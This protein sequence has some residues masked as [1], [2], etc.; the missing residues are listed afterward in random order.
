[1]PFAQL[2]EIRIDLTKP[3]KF[4]QILKCFRRGKEIWRPAGGNP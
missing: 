4:G 1:V 3:D 2:N